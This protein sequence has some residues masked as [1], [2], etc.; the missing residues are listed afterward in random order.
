MQNLCFIKNYC[1]NLDMEGVNQ[2]FLNN[3]KTKVH[4]KLEGVDLYQYKGSV[5]KLLGLTVEVK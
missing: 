5:S 2:E 1:Y 4:D 3:L